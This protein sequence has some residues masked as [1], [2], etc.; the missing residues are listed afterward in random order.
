MEEEKELPIN[1]RP[2]PQTDEPC[3]ASNI[4]GLKVPESIHNDAQSSIAVSPNA[5]QFFG[6]NVQSTANTSLF[7]PVT[8]SQQTSNPTLFQT[9][10]KDI[11]PEPIATEAVA[12]TVPGS[13]MGNLLQVFPSTQKRLTEFTKTLSANLTPLLN[14]SKPISVQDK[15]EMAAAKD[16]FEYF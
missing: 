12:S 5:S 3:I 6:H 4:S 1:K 8:G 2:K 13:Y 16:Y 15:K 11:S 7:M 10:K 9:T 14:M